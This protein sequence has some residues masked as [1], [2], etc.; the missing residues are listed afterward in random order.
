MSTENVISIDLT[1]SKARKIIAEIV[2][3]SA[4][5]MITKHARQRMRQRQI[6][7]TQV[8]RCIKHGQITEGPYRAV[9]GNWQM[10]LSTISAGDPLTVAI[11]LDKDENGNHII[12][13]TTYS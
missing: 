13:I 10:N 11:A 1:E 8:I 2:E 5:V 9:K 3:D 6:T 7:D 4:K 12:V